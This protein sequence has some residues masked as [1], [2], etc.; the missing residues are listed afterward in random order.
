MKSKYKNIV[1]LAKRIDMYHNEIME[2]NY[3][4]LKKFTFGG[5][6]ITGL[7]SLVALMFAK[8]VYFTNEYCM[9]FV[10]FVLS[11]LFTHFC[12]EKHKRYT[13]VVLYIVLLPI[14]AVGILMGT[15]L[16][17]DGAAITIMV[18]LC[19][20]SM[21][22]TDKPVH[23]ISYI[24]G[25]S[26][27]FAVCSYVSKTFDLFVGDL[28][29]LAIY[30]SVGISVNMLTL[31]DR[32]DSVENQVLLSR[33]ADIDHLTHV[34]NRGAGDH[35]ARKLLADGHGGSY[36]IMDIDNFKHY[37]DTYGHQ[38]GDEVICKVSQ[39][40]KDAFRGD[41]VVWRL[42]GDE[43]AVFATDLLS[44]E[45]CQTRM[46]QVQV[47]L[48][49]IHTSDSKSLDVHVSMGCTICHSA[50]DDFDQIYKMSDQALYEAKRKGKN[51]FVIHEI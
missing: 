39:A 4:N 14:Y 24:L 2:R 23:V 36:M 38:V 12:L 48:Q 35:A 9:C 6:V 15:F 25:V 16:D 21:F 3:A 29:N 37:N 50:H 5:M 19:T 43:F 20:L 28:V 46:K 31:T 47:N 45:I 42:G 30:L 13:L 40:L 27:A 32:V 51:C 22:I 10:T 49:S 8:R 34:L 7:I 26:L 17:P 33:K 18:L 11:Y 41:D 1:S 44:K